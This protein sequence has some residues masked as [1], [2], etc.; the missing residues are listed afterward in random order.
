MALRPIHLEGKDWFTEAEAAEY[1][2]VAL[3]TFREGYRTL[4]IAPKRFMGRKLYARS[5]LFAAIDRSPC[6]DPPHAS[7]RLKVPSALLDAYPNLRAGRLRP[8]KPRKK[9]GADV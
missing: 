6:W 7:P 3:S 9:R 4:G 8:Y 2:G 5:D 1:C